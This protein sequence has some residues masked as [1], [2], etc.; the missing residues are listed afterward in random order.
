MFLVVDRP[1]NRV[2][3]ASCLVFVKDSLCSGRLSGSEF[4]KLMMSPSW[5]RR[6]REMRLPLVELDRLA[7]DRSLSGTFGPQDVRE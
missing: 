4:I 3:R 5:T 2:T 7:H 1:S 6:R